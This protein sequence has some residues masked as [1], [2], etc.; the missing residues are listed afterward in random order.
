MTETSPG[1][2]V[3]NA[4]AADERSTLEAFLEYYRDAVIRKVSGISED[5]AR[6]RLVP[7]ATTLGG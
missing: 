2:A 6:R 4:A 1:A 7:S 3:I 5:G